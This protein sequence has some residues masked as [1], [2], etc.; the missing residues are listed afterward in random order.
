MKKADVITSFVLL[1]LSGYVIRE[2]WLMPASA[3]FGPGPGF[4]P[5]WLGVLLAALA[6]ILLVT[7]W[8]RRATERDGQS[9]F[10]GG[11]ALLSAIAS[12]SPAHSG[13]RRSAS[14]CCRAACVRRVAPRRLHPPSQLVR[15]RM[16]S[17]RGSR[18]LA[19][20][21]GSSTSR[22]R[23]ATMAASPGRIIQTPTMN[24]VPGRTRIDGVPSR[25]RRTTS[26][27][28]SPSWPASQVRR[29]CG[30]WLAT[31]GTKISAF[32]PRIAA[33][34]GEAP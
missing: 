14:A 9:P 18:R 21:F 25:R 22:R 2:S 27:A 13:T 8:R 30:T 4:L 29:T 33:A 26:S 19:H 34:D 31:S 17:A 28:S 6:L 15:S 11:R 10:P 1:V 12:T 24:S 16:V 7:A 3:T 32:T 5:L 23:S 20:A